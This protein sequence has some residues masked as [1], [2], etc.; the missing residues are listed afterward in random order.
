MHLCRA[1]TLT[2]LSTYYIASLKVNGA[3][4]PNSIHE[5][6][7]NKGR[8]KEKIPAFQKHILERHLI[9]FY[10]FDVCFRFC[11]KYIFSQSS[12]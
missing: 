6:K 1:L 10:H 9:A 5:E 8:R 12:Y 3:E 2:E 11:K 7:Y 4:V